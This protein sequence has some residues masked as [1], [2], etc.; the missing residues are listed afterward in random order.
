MIFNFFAA[1]STVVKLLYPTLVL[2]IQEQHIERRKIKP[3]PEKQRGLE[4]KNF[5]W[6]KYIKERHID[7]LEYRFPYRYMQRIV[8]FM[9]S[10]LG[11]E[12][13]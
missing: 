3:I 11:H 8:S 5:P 4:L 1:Q 7:L 2:R 9:L 13:C 6:G 12:F 10:I